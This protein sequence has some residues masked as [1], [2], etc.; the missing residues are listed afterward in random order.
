MGQMEQKP[1]EWARQLHPCTP[2]RACGIFNSKTLQSLFNHLSV[3]GL[4]CTGGNLQRHRQR[5]DLTGA[6]I[7]R[8]IIW[9]IHDI[10]PQH[11]MC[12]VVSYSLVLCSSCVSAASQTPDT[13]CRKWEA[14][15]RSSFRCVSAHPLG[16]NHVFIQLRPCPVSI[17][18]LQL[19][20]CAYLSPGCALCTC[21][22]CCTTG[23]KSRVMNPYTQ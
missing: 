15:S 18:P 9:L 23:L 10:Y 11:V 7:A 14:A 5:C 12:S 22:V 6:R 2:H 17:L 16:F 21:H 20:P 4:S 13:C 1:K 3:S 8:H 19:R